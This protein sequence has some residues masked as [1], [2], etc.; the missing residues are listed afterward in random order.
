V[1][2]PTYNVL[3]CRALFLLQTFLVVSREVVDQ[4]SM[5]TTVTIAGLP[6]KHDVIAYFYAHKKAWVVVL[7]GH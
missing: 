6:L 7:I 4:C 3:L 2:L 1:Q 5:L